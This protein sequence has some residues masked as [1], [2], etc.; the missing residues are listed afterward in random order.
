METTACATC[1]DERAARR[2][3][4]TTPGSY[5]LVLA[6]GKSGDALF[7]SRF[8]ALVAGCECL[9][10]AKWRQGA[11]RGQK[12]LKRPDRLRPAHFR[13]SLSPALMDRWG[14]C[15]TKGRATVNAYPAA[16]TPSHGTT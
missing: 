4:D 8:H 2:R 6:V 9:V 3:F 13:S 12:E 1:S 11:W 15:H 14:M 5:V 10:N 7:L 16:A